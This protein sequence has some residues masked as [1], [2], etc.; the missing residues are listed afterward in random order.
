ML[1]ENHTLMSPPQTQPYEGTVASTNLH[2]FISNIFFEFCFYEKKY[3]IYIS[4]YNGFL[5]N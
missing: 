5:F 1:P 4:I 3:T 2:G